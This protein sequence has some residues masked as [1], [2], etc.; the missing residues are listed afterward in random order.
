M[1]TIKFQDPLTNEVKYSFYKA[2]QLLSS[3]IFIRFLYT[4]ADAENLSIYFKLLST[5]A[6]KS[7]L[8]FGGY[9][10]FRNQISNPQNNKRK[11]Y[12]KYFSQIKTSYLIIFPI[13]LILFGV[14]AEA[15]L[16]GIT[17]YFL[18]VFQCV[19]QFLVAIGQHKTATKYDTIVLI[20]SILIFSTGIFNDVSSVEPI[21]FFFMIQ[22]INQLIVFL[23]ENKTAN[24]TTL[25]SAPKLNIQ[26]LSFQIS[27][28]LVTVVWLYSI[29]FFGT[30]ED[31]NTYSIQSKLY[32]VVLM[33]ITILAST[34]WADIQQRNLVKYSLKKLKLL[35]FG[36]L[37]SNSIIYFL[38]PFFTK[39]WLGD[40][41]YTSSLSNYM[42]IYFNLVVTVYIILMYAK[43]FK[44]RVD[45][46]ITAS[47][48]LGGVFLNNINTT[49]LSIFIIICYVI[50]RIKWGG[51]R[52]YY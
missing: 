3:I 2:L 14:N 9:T 31:L 18:W 6:L 40:Y 15:V 44:I 17:T 47:L 34:V 30:D 51:Q 11:L 24:A 4:T 7:V 49:L 42:F 20:T 26:D 41:S 32:T 48:A 52:L 1:K 25:F 38:N 43:S 12:D 29:T 10:T 28:T 23:H 5:Y 37:I 21:V 13:I 35:F 27:I 39:L 46:R 45:Y 8:D 22:T 50:I 19:N 33:G 36:M 16:L